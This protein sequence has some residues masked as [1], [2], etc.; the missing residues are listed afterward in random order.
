MTQA[1]PLLDHARALFPASPDGAALRAASALD[2]ACA[3]AWRASD[4]P[5]EAIAYQARGIALAALAATL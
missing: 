3:R 2:L 5:R 1:P 4:T